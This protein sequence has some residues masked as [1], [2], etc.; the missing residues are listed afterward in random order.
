MSELFD[1]SYATATGALSKGVFVESD[2]GEPAFAFTII[3][4]K[5][6]EDLITKWKD[7]HDR[8]LVRVKIDSVFEYYRS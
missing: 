8:Y 5:G 2:N 3:Y 4:L 7:V 6:T 1:F